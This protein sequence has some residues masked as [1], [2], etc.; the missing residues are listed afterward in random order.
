MRDRRCG[1]VL[2]QQVLQSRS[3][4]QIRWGSPPVGDFRRSSPRRCS[5]ALVTLM[6]GKTHWVCLISCRIQTCLLLSTYTSTCLKSP[7]L[8]FLLLSRSGGLFHRPRAPA[9]VNAHTLFATCDASSPFVSLRCSTCFPSAAVGEP[10]SVRTRTLPS[11]KGK[12][13]NW[14]G[15]D[16]C[17]CCRP[18][19]FST[20]VRKIS[21]S[22]CVGRNCWKS[23]S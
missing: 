21:Y 23:C 3:L 4:P 12:T 5:L 10:T 19:W 18:G 15:W 8:S 11:P 9:C 14:E 13:E 1:C 16:G 22:L 7:P 2:F 6:K 17:F 20:S